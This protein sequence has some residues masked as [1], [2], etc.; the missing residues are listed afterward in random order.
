MCL[1]YGAKGRGSTFRYKSMDLDTWSP[2][3]ML[4]AGIF[5]LW[6]TQSEEVRKKFQSVHPLR[7]SLANFERS[8]WTITI[9]G[10]LWCLE[11]LLL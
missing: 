6:T 5:S 7:R 2:I 10:S 3:L 9:V 11:N 8:A 1:C 4:S